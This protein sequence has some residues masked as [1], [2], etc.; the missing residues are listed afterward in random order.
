MV[1]SFGATPRSPGPSAGAAG[2]PPSPTGKRQR[3][4]RWDELEQLIEE[5][6]GQ[7]FGRLGNGAGSS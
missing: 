5:R 6:H 1:I 4:L 7:L 2:R 3:S